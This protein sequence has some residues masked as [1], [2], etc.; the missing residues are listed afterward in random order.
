MRGSRKKGRRY[1]RK[2]RL[3]VNVKSA[4]VG[5]KKKKEAGEVL[6]LRHGLDEARQYE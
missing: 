6:T 5:T 4:R 2:S 1:L 3:G